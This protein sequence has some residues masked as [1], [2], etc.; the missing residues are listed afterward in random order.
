LRV[1]VR[2]ARTGDIVRPGDS[3]SKAAF[4]G[5][6]LLELQ[7]SRVEVALNDCLAQ[8]NDLLRTVRRM[9]QLPELAVP[10]PKHAFPKQCDVDRVSDG[11]F[12]LLRRA[13]TTCAN[14]VNLVKEPDP[15]LHQGRLM[16]R[17]YARALKQV[18]IVRDC[19]PGIFLASEWLVC[20]YLL[21]GSRS[22][23]NARLMAVAQWKEAL[24]A[25]HKMLAGGPGA[26]P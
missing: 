11:A 25:F 15:V 2:D 4:E 20:D 12:K 5:E 14:N 8:T 21:R 7:V 3:G 16:V 9:L 6:L 10:H 24:A 13:A 22:T 26:R 23:D 17:E 1:D 19:A 18:N